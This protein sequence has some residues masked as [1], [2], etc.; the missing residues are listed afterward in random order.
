MGSSRF[1]H[2]PKRAQAKLAGLFVLAAVVCVGSG[3][4]IYKIFAL[5]SPAPAHPEVTAAPK[6]TKV[7]SF[8]YT[9]ELKDISIPLVDKGATRVSYAQFTLVLDCGS[10]EIHRMMELNRAKLL[11]EIFEVASKFYIEDFESPDGFSKFKQTLQASYLEHFKQGA[12]RE[13][14]IKNWYIG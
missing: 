3:Y 12:P 10:K 11:D 7:P 8:T 1:G 6:V 5:R 4:S 2:L 9:L 14:A 13:I